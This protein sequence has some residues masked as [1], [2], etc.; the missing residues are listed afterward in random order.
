MGRW[1]LLLGLA[2][3][4]L[5]APAQEIDYGSIDAFYVPQADAAWPPALPL[6]PDGDGFGLRVLSRATGQW[7]VL[8]EYQRL[9]YGADATQQFRIGAGFAPQP[10]TTGVYV[11]Y[12]RLDLDR[13]DANALGVHGRVAG[14]VAPPLSL[15]AELG[16]LGVD[17]RS[18]YYDGFEFTF[19]LTWDLPEPWGLFADYRATLLD[20]RDATDKLHQDELRVGVRLRFDC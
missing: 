19:G 7:V 16:Y 9:A 1:P 6:G 14:R 11:T 2:A 12:D 10:S 8:G 15:Y 5:A 18:F 3:L 17:A 13:E 20:D 4:P